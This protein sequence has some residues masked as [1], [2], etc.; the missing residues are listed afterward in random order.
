MVVDEGVDEEEDKEVG[1]R[2]ARSGVA[3]ADWTLND[4]FSVLKASS[5]NAL[6]LV[7]SIS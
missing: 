2:F 6:L 3:T 1:E 4:E 7:A 5:V